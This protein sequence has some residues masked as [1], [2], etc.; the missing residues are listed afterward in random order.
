MRVSPRLVA[1]AIFLWLGAYLFWEVRRQSHLASPNPSTLVLLFAGLLLT[2][3][4]V[5]VLGALVIL[6]AIG[7]R[8][9]SFFFGSREEIVPGPHDN[10]ISRLARGDAQGAL[11][12]YE[13]IVAENPEDSLA[14][15][16]MARICQ[17]NLEDTAGAG[18]ILEQALGREW[19]KEQASFL[20]NR[21]AD[22]Y[23]QE[24]DPARAQA[25]LQQV[26]ET[27][28]ASKFAAN[29]HHRIAEIG[30]KMQRGGA[31]AALPDETPDAAL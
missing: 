25:V 30:R 3:T 8:A 27:M 7:E 14:W 19:T 22:V 29:A 11:A 21:L 5:A 26:A 12:E 17:R 16:E 13:R 31:R 2:G 18:A 15:S 20:A 9:G 10:A 4:I 1:L 24:E 23:L 6:P 28:P